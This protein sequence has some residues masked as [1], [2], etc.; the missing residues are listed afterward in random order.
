[1]GGGGGG[2]GY[3]IGTLVNGGSGRVIVRLTYAA[4]S[5]S[6]CSFYTGSGYYYYDFTGSGTITL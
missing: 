1:L 6:G 3:T 2:Q 5:Y 4:A